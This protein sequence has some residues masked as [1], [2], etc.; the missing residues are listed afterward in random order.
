MSNSVM[1]SMALG[2]PVIATAVGG[3]L[4]TIENGVEGLHVPVGDA[5]AAAQAVLRLASDAG[6][7]ERLG[8][9]GR[10]R[11]AS[12]FSVERMVSRYVKLYLEVMGGGVAGG[13][14]MT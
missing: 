10:E 7:R 3:N 11:I 14:A 6:L 1:E 2:V 4:E 9:A 12:E 8:R 5:T 13:S